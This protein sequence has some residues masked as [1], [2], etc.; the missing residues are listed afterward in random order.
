MKNGNFNN[1][2]KVFI[3]AELSANHNGSILTASAPALLAAFIVS[4]AV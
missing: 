4:I 1:N 2:E 3:I